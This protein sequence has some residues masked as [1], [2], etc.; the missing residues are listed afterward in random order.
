M[1]EELKFIFESAEESMTN[2]VK[3]LEKKT[4]KH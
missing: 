2:A 1:E 3:H 4:I